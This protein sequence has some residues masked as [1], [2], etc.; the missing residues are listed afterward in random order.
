[1]V[2]CTTT[3]IKADGLYFHSFVS[4]NVDIGAKSTDEPWRAGCWALCLREAFSVSAALELAGTVTIF[5]VS[6]LLICLFFPP[7]FY[8]VWI[9]VHRNASDELRLWVCVQKSCGTQL[10][11]GKQLGLHCCVAEHL[12]EEVNSLEIKDSICV[13]SCWENGSFLTRFD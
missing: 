12:L 5:K 8:C 4:L 13:L 1:M 11:N 9:Y 10:P 6:W 2:S 7:P 3:W